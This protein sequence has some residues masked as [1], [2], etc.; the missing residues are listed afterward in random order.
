M[1]SQFPEFGTAVKPI[2]VSGDSLNMLLR[3]HEKDS[4]AEAAGQV[5]FVTL[6]RDQLLWDAAFLPS[7]DSVVRVGCGF[8]ALEKTLEFS[9]DSIDTLLHL[10]IVMILF[11]GIV[12]KD[13]TE[14]TA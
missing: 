10:Q 9:G 13:C 1:V 4:L 6:W 2:V 14:V 12:S 8:T 7:G 11:V 5:A 3:H